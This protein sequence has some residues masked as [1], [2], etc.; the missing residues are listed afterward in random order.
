ML[1]LIC[2]LAIVIFDQVT[3]ESLEVLGSSA[4]QRQGVCEIQTDVS[5]LHPQPRDLELRAF[6]DQDLIQNQ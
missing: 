4:P 6:K 1:R 5:P 2:Y 3:S